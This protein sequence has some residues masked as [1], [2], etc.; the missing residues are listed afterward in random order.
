M[1]EHKE[2]VETKIT[3]LTDQVAHI[4]ESIA[5]RERLGE[6]YE[7]KKVELDEARAILESNEKSTDILQEVEEKLSEDIEQNTQ[8]LATLRAYLEENTIELEVY[9]KALETLI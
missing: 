2:Y 3:Y 6:K 9:K 7:A 8:I 1:S 5:S 4:T